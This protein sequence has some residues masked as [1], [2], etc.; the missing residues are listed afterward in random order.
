[1]HEH[2]VADKG[3]NND[4]VRKDG[5]GELQEGELHADRQSMKVAHK[6]AQIDVH[7]YDST[8]Q[9]KHMPTRSSYRGATGSVADWAA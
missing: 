4:R 9:G 8:P 2:D 6:S 1:M 3:K 7:A 5:K